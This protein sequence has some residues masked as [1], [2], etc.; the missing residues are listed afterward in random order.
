[1]S[2]AMGQEELWHE[3]SNVRGRAATTDAAIDAAPDPLSG[4]AVPAAVSL[5]E[6]IASAPGIE[7]GG[8]EGLTDAEFDAFYAAMGL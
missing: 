7:P 5:D 2:Q 6:I 1:M 8:I 4:S 3:V